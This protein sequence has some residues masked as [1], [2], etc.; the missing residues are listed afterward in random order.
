[1]MNW[2]YNMES[3]RD[4]DYTLADNEVEIQVPFIGTYEMLDRLID[5]ECERL[6]ELYTDECGDCDYR[7]EFSMVDFLTKYVSE[8]ADICKLPSLKFRYLSSPAYY[9]F[10]TDTI[11]CS[12]DKN[13]LWKLYNERLM[14]TDY[15]NAVREATTPRSGYSPYHKPEDCD[16]KSPDDFGSSALLGLILEAYLNQWLTEEVHDYVE[17]LLHPFELFLRM[18][19]YE[20]LNEYIELYKVV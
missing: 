7:A 12:V 6:E 14:P 2:T 10:E 16:Y 15:G 3:C 20:S 4:C 8:I 11:I 1:M 19:C 18:D 17:D 9:N 13:E 5:T